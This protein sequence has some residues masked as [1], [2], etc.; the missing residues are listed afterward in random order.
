MKKQIDYKEKWKIYD[1]IRFLK[2][3]LEIEI[4]NEKYLL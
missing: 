4:L 3:F 2:F 1:Y